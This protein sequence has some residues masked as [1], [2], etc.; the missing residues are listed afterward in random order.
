M[1]RLVAIT[2]ISPVFKFSLT[3]AERFCTVPSTATTYS[4]LKVPAFANPSAPTLSSSNT[5]CN[6][7][8]LSRRSIKIRLPK[9]LLFCTQPIT[10]TFSPMLALLTSVHLWLLCKPFI[11]SA[12][13][14]S[15]IL[16]LFYL[17]KNSSNSSYPSL[18]SCSFWNFLFLFM[19]TTNTCCPFSRAS[20]ACFITSTSFSAGYFFSTK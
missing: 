5:I 3:A 9:F 19:R 16:S 4:L 18:E 6:R 14:V 7:P 15:F 11:D 17:L 13:I 10:V 8:L 20:F 1:R 12:M 2:S